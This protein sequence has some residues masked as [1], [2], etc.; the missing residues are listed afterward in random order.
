MM[1]S[2]ASGNADCFLSLFFP[3]CP[4]VDVSAVVVQVIIGGDLLGYQI[5]LARFAPVAPPSSFAAG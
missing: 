3:H 2:F 5:Y 1:T 4:S